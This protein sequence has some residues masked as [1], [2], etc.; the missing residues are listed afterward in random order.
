[1]WM[2]ESLILMPVLLY[3]L[4]QQPTNG[5]RMSR[6]GPM[7]RG[8][9]KLNMLLS[10]LILAVTGGLAQEATI[11]YKRLASLLATKWNE[12]YCKVMGWLRCCLS[13]SLLRSTIA[14]VHG[15]LLINV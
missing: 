9:G 15:N 13:F 2:S 7:G 1:M 3:L 5:M 8:S 12:Q 10:H 6:A 11:F 14:C 4:S